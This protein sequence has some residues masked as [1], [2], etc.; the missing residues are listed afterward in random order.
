MTGPHPKAAL[1]RALLAVASA[2][3][4]LLVGA[5]WL[6]FAGRRESP[7]PAPLPVPAGTAA[8]A[9]APRAAPA[10]Q[11]VSVIDEALIRSLVP[12]QVFQSHRFDPVAYLLP[13][14]DRTSTFSWAEHPEGKVTIRTNNL[15]FHRDEPTELEKRGLRVVVAGDS[16]TEALVVNNS[17]SFCT[18]AQRELRRLLGR[19]DVEVLNAGVGNT[20]PTYY[21]GVLR[22]YLELDPD[23]FVAVLY[24]G[25]DF[26]DEAYLGHRL[27]RW[28]MATPGQDYRERSW[29]VAERFGGPFHQGLNQIYRW[30]VFPDEVRLGLEAALESYR[31]MKLLCDE[32]GIGLLAVL[33]PTKIDVDEDDRETWRAALTELGLGEPDVALTPEVGR[34]FLDGA[35]G[36]GIACLDP[37]E[38]MKRSEQVLYWRKDY[39]LSVVGNELLGSLI[40]RSLE[41]LL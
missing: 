34:R 8:A 22:K 21:L 19:E 37:T 36:A 23:V 26:S 11:A 1:V 15:G 3:T 14:P 35:R 41:E 4:A 18:V 9:P 12:E 29:K 6:R 39:H 16:H 2:V 32:R 31:A 10:A 28:Q 27:G 20:S 7:R 5:L 38:A 13:K 25:N 33:L 40:A 17:E 24:A 30:S